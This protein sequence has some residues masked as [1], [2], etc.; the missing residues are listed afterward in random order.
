MD[1][2]RWTNP[3]MPTCC[4]NGKY[5]RKRPGGGYRCLLCNTLFDR[6]GEVVWGKEAAPTGAAK[7][8]IIENLKKKKL[9]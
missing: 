2:E 5:I 9:I 6:K 4:D 8:E 1:Y 3:F 7:R